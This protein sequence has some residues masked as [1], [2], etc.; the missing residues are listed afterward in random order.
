M[1]LNLKSLSTAAL[2]A[3]GLA[4]TANAGSIYLTG[5]DIDFHDGQNGYD[6]VILNYLRDTT[7]AASYKVGL[8]TGGVGGI[9]GALRGAPLWAGG[10]TE[11][12][13]IGKTAAEFAAFL[14]SV[15]V[16][17]VS[18]HTSCGGCD[19]STAASGALNAFAPAIE[20][21]FNAGGDI[22]GNTSGTLGTYYNFLPPTVVATGASIAG[23]T[24]FTCTPAGVAIL[25][26]CTLSTSGTSMINGF[27]TH[28]RFSSF[29]AA[30]TVFETRDTT[31]GTETIS[32]GL[33]DRTIV[34]GGFVPEPGSLAL[35]GLGALAL[36]LSRRRAAAR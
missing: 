11:F 8:I 16:M 5:H 14:A 23:S 26:D 3:L 13:P 10:V 29:D 2:L 15:D 22:W 21:W 30:F 32:I 4:S 28:N 35:V 18:S 19:L 12:N 36:G 9:G 20:T 17:V 33:R 31:S 34:D 1:K 24:G 27:P 7:A 6:T 25:I